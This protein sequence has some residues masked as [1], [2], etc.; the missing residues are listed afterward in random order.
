MMRKDISV[1]DL[2]E[3]IARDKVKQQKEIH[4]ANPNNWDIGD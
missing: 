4:V 2:M 1:N 3:E